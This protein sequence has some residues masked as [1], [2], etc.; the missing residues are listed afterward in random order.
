MPNTSAA[1]TAATKIA[2]SVL[3]DPLSGDSPKRLS[4]NVNATAPGTVYSARP[5]EAIE[6][7]RNKVEFNHPSVVREALKRSP[8]SA[9]PLGT[10][11]D[12]SHA[13]LE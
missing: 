6:K 13:A 2:A 1:A 4:I 3:P 8:T 10:I 5:V 9:P 7:N 11:Q 12:E